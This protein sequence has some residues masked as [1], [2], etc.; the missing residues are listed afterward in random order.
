[1]DTLRNDLRYIDAGKLRTTADPLDGS[2]VISP[3]GDVIGS[4]TGALIDPARKHVPFLIVE[5]GSWLVKHRYAVPF[6]TA[7]FD[8][9]RKAL[10]V[11]AEIDALQELRGEDWFPRFS[12]EDLITA[13]FAPHAA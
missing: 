1:M 13:M 8:A 9:E 3:A 2:T 10:V 4:L 6:G 5:S 12:D 11:D 7:H